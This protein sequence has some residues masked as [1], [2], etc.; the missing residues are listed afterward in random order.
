MEQEITQPGCTVRLSGPTFSTVLADTSTAFDS[1]PT[2]VDGINIRWGRNDLLSQ[3]SPADAKLSLLTKPDRP[4]PDIAPGMEI[5][6]DTPKTTAENVTY[7]LN[8]A[9]AFDKRGLRTQTVDSSL[10]LL[11]DNSSY[12]AISLAPAQLQTPP[13]NPDAWD[14]LPSSDR[15]D[16]TVSIKVSRITNCRLLVT[17]LYMRDPYGKQVSTSDSFTLPPTTGLHSFTVTNKFNN[18]VI[19]LRLLLMSDGPRSWNAT[20]GTWLEHPEPWDE[21]PAATIED[22]TVT[23]TTATYKPVR[24]FNG[25]ISDITATPQADKNVRIDISAVDS[26]PS[27][28]ALKIGDKPW[29]REPLDK[30]LQR[31]VNLLD[32]Y[33][34][35]NNS[36]ND[37]TLAARDIDKQ[38][39]LDMLHAAARSGASLIWAGSHANTGKYVYVEDP[40][41]RPTIPTLRLSA[42]TLP[43]P[44]NV[45]R[46]YSDLASKVEVEYYPTGSTDGEPQT[47]YEISPQLMK[48]IGTRVAQ[49]RSEL[50][51]RGNASALARRYLDWSNLTDWRFENVIIDS[52]LAKLTPGEICLLLN[53]YRRIGLPL[54]ITDLP[55]WI[56]EHEVMHVDGG[57]IAYQKKRW[58]MNLFLTPS[59]KEITDYGDNT[60]N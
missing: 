7:R 10:L 34:L 5:E 54:Q 19:G 48:R 29:G 32:G 36:P 33:T 11:A 8:T 47:L 43:A 59:F 51:N 30:R 16:F 57:T 15:D 3:P 42:K 45:F 56:P 6:I 22:I 37:V 13:H 18:G 41:E 12:H 24:I 49:I 27:L 40:A 9:N 28:A 53:S 35:I 55:P 1:Q 17:P 60:Y 20:P 14:P 23:L 46:D 21:A 38:P 52:K 25:T 4:L 31:I 39:A 44:V 2:L 26:L 50:A 58:T